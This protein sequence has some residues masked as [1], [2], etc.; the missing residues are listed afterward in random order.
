MATTTIRGTQV[1]F[2]E[3]GAGEIVVMLH[4]TGSS[5]G[6]WRSLAAALAG[7]FQ[8]VAPDLY[9]YGGTDA[10]AGREAITLADEAALV[11]SLIGRFDAPVHLVGH[12]F[13]GAV[14]LR[15]ARQAAHRI[16][17]LCLI[18]PVA[19]HLLKDGDAVDA[20]AWQEVEGVVG[21]LS[22][23]LLRGDY[24]GGC[25]HFVD[26]WSGQG[27]WAS[28]SEAKRAAL[29]QKLGKVVLDFWTSMNEPTRMGD[30]EGCRV[31]TLVIRGGRSPHPV[32][33]IARHIAAAMPDARL[34]EI[35]SAG[36]MAP[37]THAD[38]VNRLVTQHIEGG[39][40]FT[41]PVP[42]EAAPLRPLEVASV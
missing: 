9:G 30:L 38:E 6:Q 4:C 18:E 2:S 34:A 5:G 7:R 31:P 29:A 14:A 28:M 23:A 41:S 35:R 22:R 17:T 15:V 21:T 10:W 26:Y 12:S 42:I 33:R 39:N 8:S 40:C 16:R 37:M 27:A 1:A 11:E 36:H 32:R 13:G 24:W 19:F 3:Q 25:G 20:I